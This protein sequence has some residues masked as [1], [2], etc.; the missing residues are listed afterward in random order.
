MNTISDLVF[1]DE[2]FDLK[3]MTDESWPIEFFFFSVAEREPLKKLATLLEIHELNF[4]GVRCE[5]YDPGYDD[6]PYN[7]V[8]FRLPYWGNESGGEAYVSIE[9]FYDLLRLFVKSHLHKHPEDEAELR[10][11]FEER[12]YLNAAGEITTGYIP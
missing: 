3:R 11:M 9:Q 10:K 6:I 12:G 5:L 1:L 7:G 8:R 2:H 4:E